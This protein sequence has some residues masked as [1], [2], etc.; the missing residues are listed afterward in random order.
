[1]IADT[2]RT[3]IKIIDKMKE[4]YTLNGFL[5]LFIGIFGIVFMQWFS[6]G[7]TKPIK[8]LTFAASLVSKGET[9]IQEIPI[10][11]NDEVSILANAFNN[12]VKKINLQILEIKE[13][14]E[15]EARLKNE[16]MEILEVK[17]L[18]KETELKSLQSRINPHFLFNSLN[19]ISQMAY[20]EGASQTTSLLEAMTDLLRYNLDKFNKVVT[21]E[22]EVQYLRDYVFIQ[23]KRFGG[24][25]KFEIKEDKDA[26]SCLIPC[27]IIQPLV[28]NSII[29]GVQSYTQNGLVRIE[30]LKEHQRVKIRIYDN[31]IGIPKEK[32]IEIQQILEDGLEIYNSDSIGIYNVI[33]RLRLFY[34]ND[35]KAR[36][37][38][39]T[40]NGTEIELDIPFKIVGDNGLCIA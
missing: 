35:I 34:N 27:L 38:S 21:I 15:L 5:L 4:S 11:S 24:R 36:I 7:I 39:N 28:E 12:M 29:H 2:Q 40:G 14:A 20:I 3:K 37:I 18:L 16:E 9:N 8:N 1:L 25:I 19:I 33:A 32:L 26:Y 31:G 17:N 23:V 22:N 6:S 30:V 10:N 13:K